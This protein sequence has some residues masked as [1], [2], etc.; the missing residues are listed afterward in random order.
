M[1]SDPINTDGHYYYTHATGPSSIGNRTPQQVFHGLIESARVALGEQLDGLDKGRLQKLDQHAHDYYLTGKAPRKDSIP[2]LLLLSTIEYALEDLSN[3]NSDTQKYEGAI[4]PSQA[5]RLRDYAEREACL[6][7]I[8][9]NDFFAK[10]VQQ[11][12]R[13]IEKNLSGALIPEEIEFFVNS[14]H[15]MVVKDSAKLTDTDVHQYK[16]IQSLLKQVR[17]V[18]QP[19]KVEE[20][21]DFSKLTL[22]D[23]EALTEHFKSIAQNHGA[24]ME[25][26]FRKMFEGKPAQYLAELKLSREMFPM[27]QLTGSRSA[28]W[29][30][31]LS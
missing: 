30:N 7:P 12:T 13:N 1:Q 17:D 4:L 16:A 2:H 15:R 5:K 9:N 8:V 26:D 20:R 10:A 18:L 28:G 19:Y 21:Y 23:A 27:L 3:Y 11:G 29:T 24:L 6:K 22:K 14:T 31:S 25:K